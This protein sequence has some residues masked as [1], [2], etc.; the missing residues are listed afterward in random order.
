MR[1]SK[2][3]GARW[4]RQ[5]EY[6]LNLA[7]RLLADGAY[8]YAAFFAEQAAQKSL[9]A[10]LLSRGARMVAIHSVGKL[11]QE[12]AL[13]DARFATVVMP[14]RR[15]DRHYLTSRYPDALPDPAIPA[16]SYALEDAEEAVA[17]ARE[18]HGMASAAM[19]A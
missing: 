12:A 19:A 18:I 8:A 4:L 9:K 7:G 6:D 3:N 17:A 14:G 10:F 15:L 13:L 11:A 5:A 16:E 1:D 2:G